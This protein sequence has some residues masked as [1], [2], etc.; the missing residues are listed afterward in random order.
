MWSKDKGLWE[1]GI[2]CGYK[3]CCGTCDERLG[4]LYQ[5][6]KQEA[7]KADI[8]DNCTYTIKMDEYIKKLD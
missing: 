5:C 2:N 3:G 8:C 4:C 1:R 6:S 7:I